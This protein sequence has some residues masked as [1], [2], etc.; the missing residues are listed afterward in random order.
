MPSSTST[1]PTSKFI[2]LKR[3]LDELDEVRAQLA[4]ADEKAANA[5]R[6]KKSADS[7]VAE[8]HAHIETLHT[9]LNHEHKTILSLHQRLDDASCC[10]RCA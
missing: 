7:N 1:L 6:D 4:E 10:H 9:N 5:V 8:L 2:S 3:V